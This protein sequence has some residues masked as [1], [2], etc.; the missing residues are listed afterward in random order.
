MDKIDASQVSYSARALR[1]V[2]DEGG[3][4]ARDI[5]DRVE[6][7]GLSRYCRGHRRPDVDTAAALHDLSYGRVPAHGWALNTS[8]QSKPRPISHD[9][10]GNPK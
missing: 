8:D 10:E 9:F 3:Q 2:L 6:S 5:R 4:M 1:A 7:G